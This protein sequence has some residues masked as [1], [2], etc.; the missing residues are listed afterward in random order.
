VSI[1]DPNGAPA[2]QNVPLTDLIKSPWNALCVVEV[3]IDFAVSAAGTGWL[4]GSSTVVTAA[5]V[6]AE[7]KARPDVSVRVIYASGHRTAK[8]I[9]CEIHPEYRTSSGTPYA[10]FDVA[11]LRLPD[12]VRAPIERVDLVSPSSRPT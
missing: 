4:A 10:P 7:A 5:H 11:A 2:W 3:V 1:R 6:V 8:A 9:A 12:G